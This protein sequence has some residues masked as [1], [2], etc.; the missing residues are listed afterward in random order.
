MTIVKSKM[1]LKNIREMVEKIS[2]RIKE[3]ESVLW[4]SEQ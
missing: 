4:D 3:K 1:V 2:V